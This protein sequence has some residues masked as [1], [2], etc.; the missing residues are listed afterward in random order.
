[1]IGQIL[2]TAG[3]EYHAP[4]S[5]ASHRAFHHVDPRGL[6]PAGNPGGA[7][8]PHRPGERAHH[9]AATTRAAIRHA[10]A[11]YT[12]CIGHPPRH[13]HPDGARPDHA[14]A[15]PRPA[16]RGGAGPLP[17]GDRAAG[18]PSGGRS[19]AAGGCR[20]TA[21][22][23]RRPAGAAR[24][25]AL[26]RPDRPLPGARSAPRRPG[27]RA[28]RRLRLRPRGRPEPDGPRPGEHGGRHGDRP[29]GG[30]GGRRA[31]PARRGRGLRRGRE[32][33]PV[34]L[35]PGGG[36]A[37][38][39]AGRGRRGRGGRGRG[40]G[41]E[42]HRD[43]RA[44]VPPAAPPAGSVGLY[45]VA[46]RQPVLGRARGGRRTA[47]A[48]AGRRAGRDGGGGRPAP[49]RNPRGRG[50]EDTGAE[51]GRRIAGPVRPGWRGRRP[52]P[53]RAAGGR[54]PALRRSRERRVRAGRG[55]PGGERRHPGPHHRPG[56]SG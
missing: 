3:S 2:S 56:G 13:A 12:P 50:R 48:V 1:M 45:I 18:R 6:R 10:A 40:R 15:R 46:A 14:H 7:S 38:R 24:R 21:R 28:V 27:G 25:A 20:R 55:R 49:D 33:Q 22:G 42:R 16:H 39:R 9:P 36:P 43:R 8:G 53:D 44:R 17:R 23:V 31:R 32:Q 26:L 52:A 51:R 37:A 54:G 35:R 19:A 47:G 11:V 30:G 5:Y 4:D 41:E 34:R 29:A